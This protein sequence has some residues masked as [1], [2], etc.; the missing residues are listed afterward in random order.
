[1]LQLPERLG[2]DL[3]DA[4]AGDRELLANLFQRVVGVHTDAEAHAQHALFARRQRSQHAGGSLAQVRLDGGVDRQDRFLVLDETTE[5][6]VFLVADRRF[7]RQR[8]LGDFENLC[9]L[10]TSPSPRDRTRSRMP[11]SA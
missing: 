6:A 9:L 5:M 2:L 11:S 1:M 10:Y 7:Q 8:L 4:L 3:P